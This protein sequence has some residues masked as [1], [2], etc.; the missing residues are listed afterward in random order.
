MTRA[1]AKEKIR[2]AGGELSGSIS[3]KTDYLVAG[4]KSGGKLDRAKKLGIKI[5]TE[6]EFLKMFL[7]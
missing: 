1:E 2:Q 6:A 7:I 5:L 4:D 3:Q